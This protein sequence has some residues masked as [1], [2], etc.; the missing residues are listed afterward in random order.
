MSAICSPIPNILMLRPSSA[1]CPI[2]KTRGYST[3][4]QVWPQHFYN[5]P[6]VAPFIH[7]VCMLWKFV[8]YNVRSPPPCQVDE[9]SN[10]ICTLR[11]SKQCP[12]Y[13]NLE[14]SPKLI[15]G[16]CFHAFRRPH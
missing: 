6:E 12:I 11:K 3:G 4:F 7:A 10:A 9:S 8:P 1:V 15:H 2:L 13:W 14:M 5:S 16:D